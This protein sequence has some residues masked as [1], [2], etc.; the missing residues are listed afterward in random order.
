MINYPEDMRDKPLVRVTIARK[1][2]NC[3][4]L[5][6]RARHEIPNKNLRAVELS[7]GCNVVLCDSCAT[8]VRDDR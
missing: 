5:C 4:N 1:G 8:D 7:F 2:A 3:C 6:G